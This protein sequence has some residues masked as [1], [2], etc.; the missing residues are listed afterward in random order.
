M[1]LSV[2]DIE[3]KNK[4]KKDHITLTGF[5]PT[6]SHFSKRR[7]DADSPDVSE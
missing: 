7:V 6:S 5:E 3:R 1:M 2:C 4:R